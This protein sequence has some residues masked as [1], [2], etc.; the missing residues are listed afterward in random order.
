MTRNYP[1]VCVS[2]SVT[3]GVLLAVLL[4]LVNLVNQVHRLRLLSSLLR[5]LHRLLLLNQPHHPILLTLHPLRQATQ[6]PPQ[7]R[8]I[9]RNGT[10]LR[11]KST[12]Q[13]PSLTRSR[14]SITPQKAIHRRLN[15]GPLTPRSRHKPR[16]GRGIRTQRTRLSLAEGGRAEDGR[17]DLLDVA[18]SYS[19]I[20]YDT[21]VTHKSPH[22]ISVVSILVTSV[23]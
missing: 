18:I 13:P 9:A 3:P 12:S 6:P 11:P 4:L 22:G 5:H 21:A 20:S 1:R 16:P 14:G 2:R 17:F 15:D 10:T 23:L 7:P 19:Q 8:K